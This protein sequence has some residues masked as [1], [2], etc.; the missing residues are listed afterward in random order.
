MGTYNEIIKMSDGRLDEM[1]EISNIL[2]ILSQE[3]ELDS[4]ANNRHRA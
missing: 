3:E 2:T 4:N 1:M